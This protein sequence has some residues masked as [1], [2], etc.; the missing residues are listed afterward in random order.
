M[1]S[2]KFG[3]FYLDAYFLIEHIIFLSK[4]R[5]FLL[6]QGIIPILFWN[7]R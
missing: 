3:W 7:E 1:G 2:R 5:N 4:E 6:Q